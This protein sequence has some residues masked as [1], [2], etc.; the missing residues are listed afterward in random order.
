VVPITVPQALSHNVRGVEEI[1]D[2]LNPLINDRGNNR[3]DDVNRKCRRYYAYISYLLPTTKYRAHMRMPQHG[4][5]AMYSFGSNANPLLFTT[6]IT[7]IA[8]LFTPDCV[9]I[10]STHMYG[11][12][13]DTQC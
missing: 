3:D 12:I 11:T 8:P 9:H 7:N 13:G 2:M 10:R 1:C 4:T 6:N 5:Y